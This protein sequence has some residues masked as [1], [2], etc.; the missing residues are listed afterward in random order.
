MNRRTILLIAILVWWF[1]AV[2][3]LTGII[4]LHMSKFGQTIAWPISLAIFVTPVLVFALKNGKN[5]G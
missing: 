3:I 5:N 1:V 2:Q 4:T